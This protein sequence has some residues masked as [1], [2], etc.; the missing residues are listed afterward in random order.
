MSPEISILNKYMKKLFPFILEVDSLTIG[1]EPYNQDNQ[2]YQ[3]TSSG[4]DFV[5]F[6][7]RRQN[8]QL[9]LNIYVSPIHF[10]ELMDGRVERKII[11][12]MINNCS[13]LLKSVIPSWNGLDPRILFY[14]LIGESATILEGINI[15][16]EEYKMGVEKTSY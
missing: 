10:C 3:I 13:P 1:N 15:P 9:Q 11:K 6:T 2:D 7:S 5:T 8:N 4:R 14:P 12:H 16:S